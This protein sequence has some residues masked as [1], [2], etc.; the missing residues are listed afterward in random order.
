MS[1]GINLVNVFFSRRF[2]EIDPE[3]LHTCTIAT[4]QLW[5]LGFVVLLDCLVISKVLG[6]SG[7]SGPPRTPG[8]W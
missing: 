1:N 5:D 8:I 4:M 7:L 2:L 6:F 3:I